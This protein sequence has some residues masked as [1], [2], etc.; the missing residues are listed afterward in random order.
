MEAA[1]NAASSYHDKSV[2][3]TAALQIQEKYGQERAKRLR[4]EGSA[5]YI[6]LSKSDKFRHLQNDPW[7]DDASPTLDAASQD[8]T[9]CQVLVLGAGFGGLQFAVRLIE[10]GIDVKRIRIIDQ[11]GGFGGTWYWNRFPGLM[12]DIESYIYLPLLEETGYIPKHKYSYGPELREYCNIIAKKWQ[13]TDKALFQTRMTGMV[14]NDESKQWFVSMT[15]TSDSK[16]VPFQMRVQFVAMASG[17]LNYPQI[18]NLPGVDLFKGYTFHT[19]RW[20]Y[21]Y[22]GGSPTDPSLEQLKDKNVAIIGTGATA[23]QTVP[24]LAKWAKH[25]Y[26]FQRTP[27]A[28]DARGQRLTDAAW[29]AQEVAG[30]KGWQEKRNENFLAQFTDSKPP[31][32]IDDGFSNMASYRAVIGKPGIVE[33]IPEYVTA[34][35]ELDLPRQER[36]RARIEDI[37]TNKSAAQNLKAWYPGWCKRPCFH[38]DYLPAFN[39][40]NVTLVD[41]EGRGVDR[42]TE[43][44]LVFDGKEYPVDLIVFSTGY[45]S[46]IGLGPAERASMTIHGRNGQTLSEK[47]AGGL[48]TLHGVATN[49]FPNLFWAG[50]SQAGFNP[51]QTFSLDVFAKHVAFIISSAIKKAGGDKAVSVEPSQEAEEAWAVQV[52]R[53]AGAMAGMGGCTPSYFNRE[54][55]A[56]K[57]KSEA[58][59][60]EAAKQA[61]WGEG[62]VSYRN[63]VEEWKAKGNLEGLIIEVA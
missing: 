2:E 41:T 24:H 10:A 48:N 1:A 8:D 28:V 19:S 44:A 52:A 22:T 3:G 34:L 25:L 43:G 47:T 63:V 26:V 11:A 62:I 59:Q 45:S 46:P 51:N 20:H 12:C 29:Y 56:D 61:P 7:L 35:H 17:G 14:W 40:P 6:D 49:N 39:Q 60:F 54:G 50:I 5:Q 36:L 53:R 38:D 30:A 31:D 18:P 37:V 33:A 9:E 55:E 57:E 21:S 42:L 58:E 15:Q 16:E 4:P 27:S 32:M 13:L 23:I